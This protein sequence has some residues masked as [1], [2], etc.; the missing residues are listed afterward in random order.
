[1][2]MFSEAHELPKNGYIAGQSPR[3]K[4]LSGPILLLWV[5][6][7][8][9]LDPKLGALVMVVGNPTNPLQKTM[10]KRT[11]NRPGAEPP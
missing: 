11:K 10:R 4:N 9:V 3:S 2:A 8:R 7:G 6:L 1:M 5:R